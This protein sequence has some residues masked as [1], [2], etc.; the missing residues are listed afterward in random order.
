M[1][2]WILGIV[3]VAGLVAGL[4]A[5]PAFAAGSHPTSYSKIFGNSTS[6]AY[7]RASINDDTY[8]AGAKTSNFAGCDTSNATKNVP[9]GYLG[10]QSIIRNNNTGATCGTATVQ[11]NSTSTWTKERVTSITSGSESNCPLPGYYYG[12]SYNL[13]VSDAGDTYYVTKQ[14]PSAYYF[15]LRR[16]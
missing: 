6:C 12:V 11:Y 9:A 1:N 16:A 10:A 7:G 14:T 3:V 5:S 15:D 8:K 2:R 13:R 4:G